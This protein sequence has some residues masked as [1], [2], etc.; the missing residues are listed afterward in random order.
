MLL[1]FKIF[2]ETPSKKIQQREITGPVYADL[3]TYCV[4]AM[5]KQGVPNLSQAWDQIIQEQLQKECENSLSII[6]DKLNTLELPCDMFYLLAFNH[7]I[8][9]EAL[10]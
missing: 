1:Q 3:I 4:D 8:K 5:N 2:N 7:E 6:Q 10:R 9:Q